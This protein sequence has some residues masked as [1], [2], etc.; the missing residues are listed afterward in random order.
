MGWQN[1]QPWSIVGNKEEDLFQ[2]AIQFN[3][4][5]CAW[6]FSNALWWPTIWETVDTFSCRNCFCLPDQ[7]WKIQ[8]SSQKLYGW[9]YDIGQTRQMQQTLWPYGRPRN[10]QVNFYQ[11]SNFF[12]SIPE[13]LKQ[14]QHLAKVIHIV[15]FALLFL[16]FWNDLT[17]LQL[18]SMG[19]LP[20][21]SALQPLSLVTWKHVTY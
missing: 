18:G 2:T 12:C 8:H 10:Q 6:S 3:A 11:S 4:Y 19:V 16:L 13:Y 15:W 9:D 14:I 21:P 1:T 5:S 20:L 17:L 7:L